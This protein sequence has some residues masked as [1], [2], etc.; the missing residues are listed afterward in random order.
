MNTREVHAHCPGTCGEPI[1][2][3][4]EDSKFY[5]VLGGCPHAVKWMDNT[6][7][8]NERKEY[9][10]KLCQLLDAYW[11]DQWEAEQAAHEA[12]QM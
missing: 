6:M 12:S 1:D 10:K 4:Y 8:E 3:E 2:I 5:G 9:E 11:E 7:E